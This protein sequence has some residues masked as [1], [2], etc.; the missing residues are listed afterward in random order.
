MRRTKRNGS[1][2]LCLLFNM[3]LNLDGLLPAAVLFGLHFWLGLSLW[4]SLL[5]AGL[6]LLWLI[7]WM[8]VIGWAR[9]CGDTPDRP[10]ENKN[11]YS[12]KK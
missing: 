7:I 1:F 9:R 5:A 10:K 11:P 8:C 3:L 2:F 12:A 4:W 6:W